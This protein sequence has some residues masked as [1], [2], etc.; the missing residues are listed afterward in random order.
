VLNYLPSAV[1]QGGV[2]IY[3]PYPGFNAGKNL[4]KQTEL[5]FPFLYSAP[6]ALDLGVLIT[7]LMMTKSKKILAL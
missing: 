5:L 2:G 7:I 4:I 1:I 3:L 6:G